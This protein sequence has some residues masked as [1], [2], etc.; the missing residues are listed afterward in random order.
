LKSRRKS[1]PLHARSDVEQCDR[2]EGIPTAA[3][4][5][6]PEVRGAREAAVDAAITLRSTQDAREPQRQI[7]ALLLR[8]LT[9]IAGDRADD[10]AETRI[11]AQQ[12]RQAIAHE[13]FLLQ[14][15]DDRGVRELGASGRLR[16]NPC[17]ETPLQIACV[18]ATYRTQHTR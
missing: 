5:A 17:L 6:L 1:S 18:L 13:R 3:T 15:R 8:Q 10:L 12:V 16:P 14:T 4:G 11:F 7:R 2:R 9:R